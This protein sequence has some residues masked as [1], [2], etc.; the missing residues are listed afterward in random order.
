LTFK[1][2]KISYWVWSVFPFQNDGSTT[3]IF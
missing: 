2:I 3:N 1:K